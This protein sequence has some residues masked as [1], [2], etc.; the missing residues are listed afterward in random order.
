MCQDKVKGP[1]PGEDE[2]TDQD[3]GEVEE[4]PGQSLGERVDGIGAHLAEVTDELA[5]LRADIMVA[6]S[7][8]VE[9]AT[10]IPDELDVEPDDEG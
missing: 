3:T 2:D 9:T 5:Q 10:L 1:G 4:E 7:E 6:E 8:V